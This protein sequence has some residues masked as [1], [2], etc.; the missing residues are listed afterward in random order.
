MNT[1]RFFYWMKFKYIEIVITE[2]AVVISKA[3]VTKVSSNL[4]FSAMT[5]VVTAVGIVLK[6]VEIL[7]C[8]TGKLKSFK[9]QK[10]NKG[11]TPNFST[12]GKACRPKVSWCWRKDKKQPR[13]NKATGEAV[14]ASKLM[15]LLSMVSVMPKWGV[16]LSKIPKIMEIIKGFFINSPKYCFKLWCCLVQ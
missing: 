14:T 15:V 2:S 5:K 11:N 6:K 3:E 10:I 9:N 12:T 4:N 8:P 16:K 13:A 1:E 7:I